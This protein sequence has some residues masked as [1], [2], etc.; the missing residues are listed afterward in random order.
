M[1]TAI[2]HFSD[3]L[4]DFNIF[5]SSARRNLDFLEPFLW[6][7]DL[8]N[9][10]NVTSRGTYYRSCTARSFIS[11][12]VAHS[13]LCRITFTFTHRSFFTSI[14]LFTHLSA[15]GCYR[16]SACCSLSSCLAYILLLQALKD[17]SVPKCV[18]YGAVK[19]ELCFC[20]SLTFAII[21]FYLP[22]IIS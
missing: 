8:L 17:S 5:I 1:S 9:M 13:C 4:A 2:S 10:K 3:R 22:P 18:S 19:K 6:Q 14:F 20:S 15:Y 11:R 16:A 7:V 21:I 12:I